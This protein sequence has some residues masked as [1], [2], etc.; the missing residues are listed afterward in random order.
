MYFIPLRFTLKC[1]GITVADKALVH[2]MI[3]IT[4]SH[5]FFSEFFFTLTNSFETDSNQNS[6]SLVIE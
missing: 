3:S 4:P 5:V 6:F 2:R 1:Q